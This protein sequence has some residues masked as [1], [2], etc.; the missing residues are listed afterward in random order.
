MHALLAVIVIVIGVA[1]ILAFL[2]DQRK[3]RRL[4]FSLTELLDEGFGQTRQLSAGSSRVAGHFRGRRV[5]LRFRKEKLRV[6]SIMLACD[7][8]IKFI[9]VER[10]VSF[11]GISNPPEGKLIETGDPDLD[12]RFCFSDR[13]GGAFNA[14]LRKWL[15]M[16]ELSELELTENRAQI[17]AWVRRPETR[18]GLD[19]LLYR[20]AVDRVSIEADLDEPEASLVY[21][22]LSATFRPCWKKDLEPNRVR[23][24]LGEL[25]SLAQSLES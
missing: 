13:V 2:A 7:S 15:K 25:S 16:L 11:L 14:A 23:S 22:C 1:V 12:K 18:K 20:N 24:I 3:Y 17:V 21:P 10:R 6:F 8:R 4:L 9:L 5:T 19:L